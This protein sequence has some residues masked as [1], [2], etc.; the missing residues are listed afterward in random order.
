MQMLGPVETTQI[1]YYVFLHWRTRNFIDPN[2]AAA[3]GGSE[4]ARVERYQARARGSAAP[5]PR[6]PP[7][8]L[9]A[10]RQQPS[11][12]AADPGE[13]SER[14]EAVDVTHVYSEPERG[15]VMRA[16]KAGGSVTA[17]GCSARHPAAQIRWL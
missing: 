13:T 4:S 6:F 16:A 10:S 9:P 2:I 7:P 3:L 1:R 5:N 14:T 17:L 15:V 8:G 11:L 12:R